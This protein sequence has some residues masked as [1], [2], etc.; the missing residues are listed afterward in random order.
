MGV[1]MPFKRSVPILVGL[2][3]LTAVPSA[4]DIV[5]LKSGELFQTRK[6]WRENGQVHYYRNGQLVHVPDD[7]VER[8]VHDNT[9]PE[10]PGPGRS[11]S[12]GGLPPANDNGL[13]SQSPSRPSASQGDSGFR[14]L[15]WGQPVSA[16]TDLHLV[17][18]DPAYGG[19]QQYV[20]PSWPP[21][22]GRASVDNIYYGFWQG[23]LYTILI[24]VSN[25]LDYEELRAEAFRRYGKGQMPIPEMERYRW[26]DGHTDRMLSYD[27]KTKTGYLWMRSRAIHVRV[28]EMYPD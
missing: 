27:D 5:I 15:Q 13:P 19:V 2:L 3:I 17:E 14:G 1:D 20:Q 28:S 7:A 18:T 21:R 26:T 25:Y 10:S 4:A 9:V 23:S 22:F 6:A 8:L 12:A 16:F 11:Q 24:E